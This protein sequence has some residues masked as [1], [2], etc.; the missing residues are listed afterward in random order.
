MQNEG[1]AG[2]RL[3]ASVV[4]SFIPIF[5]ITVGTITLGVMARVRVSQI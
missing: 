4:R 2:R 3:T 1:A 5:W